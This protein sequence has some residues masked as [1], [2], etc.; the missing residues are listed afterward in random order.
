MNRVLKT[1][2]QAW[3]GLIGIEDTEEVKPVEEEVPIVQETAESGTASAEGDG[4]A[5]ENTT[6]MTDSAV[7]T[8]ESTTAPA[9][10]TTP[11][12]SSSPFDLEAE[13]SRREARAKRFGSEFDREQCKQVILRERRTQV[14]DISQPTQEKPDDSVIAARR[15]RFGLPDQAKEQRRR[16]R[17]GEPSSDTSIRAARVARFGEVDRSRLREGGNRKR[18]GTFS[19]SRKMRRFR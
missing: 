18:A 6:V 3:C 2:R 5:I 16:E 7:I 11:L 15:A 14:Q 9:S 13:L 8:G 10:S 19:P 12:E 1:V 17:F 4:V